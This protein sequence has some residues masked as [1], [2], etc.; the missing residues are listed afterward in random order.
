MCATFRHDSEW[1]WC[2]F[3]Q[4]IGTGHWRQELTTQRLP[5]EKRQKRIKTTT[6]TV[7]VT[8]STKR[9]KTRSPLC[10]ATWKLSRATPEASASPLE[11]AEGSDRP[12]GAETAVLGLAARELLVTRSS[13][14]P[15]TMSNTPKPLVAI[16]IKCQIASKTF[17][18]CWTTRNSSNRRLQ[19][20]S[21]SLSTEWWQ[22]HR[23]SCRHQSPPPPPPAPARVTPRALVAILPSVTLYLALAAKS[24]PKNFSF[25]IPPLQN[26]VSSIGSILTQAAVSGLIQLPL[27][28]NKNKEGRTH[29]L[30]KKDLLKDKPN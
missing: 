30:S 10:P 12:P 3:G 15:S 20:I 17:R 23:W 11:A 18:E 9:S 24:Q 14:D 5:E 4:L 26:L 28:H 8:S 2:Y 29:F 13:A 6:W 25:Q 19:T 16:T 7:A 22:G 21:S 1:Q 27:C